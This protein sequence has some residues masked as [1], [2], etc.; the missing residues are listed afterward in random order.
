[1]W[2]NLLSEQSGVRSTSCLFNLASESVYEK[3]S[4]LGPGIVGPTGSEG[5]A[6]IIREQL[7]FRGQ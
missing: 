5:R 3:E 4:S 6:G 2:A 1:M 7:G